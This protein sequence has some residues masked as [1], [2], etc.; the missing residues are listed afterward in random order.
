MNR[1]TRQALRAEGRATRSGRVII[2]DV[3]PSEHNPSEEVRPTRAAQL[4]AARDAIHIR[5][6]QLAGRPR[7]GARCP[8]HPDN[9]LRDL[10]MTVGTTERSWAGFGAYGARVSHCDW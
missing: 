7:R 8:D 1:R 2:R 6:C 10:G 5:L 9:V 4:S 3:E